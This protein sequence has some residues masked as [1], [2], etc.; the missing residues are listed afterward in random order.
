MQPLPDTSSR[1]SKGPSA[2]GRASWSYND[3]RCS[4]NVAPRGW[5]PAESGTQPPA[6][7]RVQLQA[8]SARLA[9]RLGLQTA[10]PHPAAGT[11]CGHPPCPRLPTVSS[12]SDGGD[13]PSRGR[14]AA[15]CR[16]SPS[17][18]PPPAV[19]RPGLGSLPAHLLLLLQ[20]CLGN[21]WSVFRFQN[22]GRLLVS[23]V[24]SSSL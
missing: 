13:A 19:R 20:L 21:S 5:K 7:P 10:G 24:K 9:G 22:N 8:A 4:A 23:G 18:T 14:G 1:W 16:R 15:G 6:I 12:A 3:A 2:P 17:P 11:R